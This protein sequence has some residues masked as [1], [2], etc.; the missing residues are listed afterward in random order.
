MVK[1]DIRNICV[2]LPIWHKFCSLWCMSTMSVLCGVLVMLG[3]P[4]AAE[5]GHSGVLGGVPPR[6]GHGLHGDAEKVQH[7]ITF[8]HFTDNHTHTQTVANSPSEGFLISVYLCVLFLFSWVNRGGH[9]KNI[10]LQQLWMT[11]GAF[12]FTLNVKMLIKNCIIY[13]FFMISLCGQVFII[14]FICSPCSLCLWVLIVMCNVLCG[15][16]PS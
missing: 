5:Q 3:L 14:H 4:A 15:S 11:L 9:Q 12:T 1:Y 8:T 7:L 6:A 2:T 13:I 16:W 10:N